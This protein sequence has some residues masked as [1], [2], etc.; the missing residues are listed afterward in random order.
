M[1]KKRRGCRE[2]RGA[3]GEGKRKINVLGVR[4]HRKEVKGLYVSVGEK[5]GMVTVMGRDERKGHYWGER[6][7]GRECER[8]SKIGIW[9]EKNGQ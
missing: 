7:G 3:S 9:E 2:R 1:G 4:D 5:G 8:G 6:K